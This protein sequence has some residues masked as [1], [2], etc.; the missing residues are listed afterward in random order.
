VGCAVVMY[1]L[2]WY[3]PQNVEESQSI[4]VEPG[5]AIALL[6]ERLPLARMTEE[7]KARDL[8]NLDVSNTSQTEATSSTTGRRHTSLENGAQMSTVAVNNSSTITG[9]RETDSEDVGLGS[10]VGRKLP[11]ADL[12]ARYT[13]VGRPLNE[14]WLYGDPEHLLLFPGQSISGFPFKLVCQNTF[15]MNQRKL[16]I[17]KLMRDADEAQEERWRATNVWDGL[18]PAAPNVTVD[19]P[20][21]IFA[22]HQIFGSLALLS[23]IY[24]GI[25]ASSWNGHFPSTI[26][27]ILWQVA[28]CIVGV[29]AVSCWLVNLLYWNAVKRFKYKSRGVVRHVWNT[30][31]IGFGFTIL[32]FFILFFGSR[33]FLVVESFISVRS[34]PVGAYN[35][36]N[37]VNFLP[38][39]G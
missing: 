39:I 20:F 4:N 36:T 31:G 28:V 33:G 19:D 18:I 13:V 27:R 1:A 15:N 12:R 37:W 24:G 6:G 8:R 17:L 21:D 7:E 5:L 14:T 23:F 10:P 32:F 35:T 2:W 29:G 38:H 30:V 16:Q 9:E 34:L 22:S 11:S 3:K 26:E 25:H